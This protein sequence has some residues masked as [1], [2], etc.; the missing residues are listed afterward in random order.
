MMIPVGIDIG[1]FKEFATSG[2]VDVLPAW[3]ENKAG[4]HEL[5]IARHTGIGARTLAIHAGISDQRRAAKMGSKL[6]KENAA[7]FLITPSLKLVPT[8]ITRCTLDI[9]CTMSRLFLSSSVVGP[10]LFDVVDERHTIVIA[11]TVTGILPMGSEGMGDLHRSRHI[12][13]P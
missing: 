2:N 5:A 7:I 12:T 4:E 1:G 13:C 6:A 11:Q 9:G 8:R 3:R 10:G